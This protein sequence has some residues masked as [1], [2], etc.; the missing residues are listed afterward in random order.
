MI[1]SVGHPTVGSCYRDF[2]VAV[3]NTVVVSEFQW[4]GRLCLSTWADSDMTAIDKGDMLAVNIKSVVVWN[5]A[6]T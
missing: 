3:L 2:E 5:T 6:A 1:S 4:G